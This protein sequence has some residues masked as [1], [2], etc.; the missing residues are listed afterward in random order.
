M[1]ITTEINN[2]VAHI[3]F[4]DGGLNIITPAIAAKFLQTVKFIDANPDVSSLLIEGNGRSF[5]AGLD[6]AVLQAGGAPAE[7][8]QRDTARLLRMLYESRLRVVSLC[9][10]HA[11]AVGAM[12]L[13]VSD[14]RVGVKDSGRIGFSEV[15]NGFALSEISILL[16]KDR[17]NNKELFAATVLARMYSPDNA[18]T[19]GF[20]DIVM[21]DYKGAR[22]HAIKEA[23]HLGKLDDEVYLTTMMRVRKKTLSAAREI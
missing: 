6:T 21:G 12:L 10:G 13:L 23:Q 14:Y 16:A 1:P 5:S 18:N 11:T 2:S 15:A 8:M 4:D 9:A 20:L 19:A 3:R 17:L 22:Y 7:Q